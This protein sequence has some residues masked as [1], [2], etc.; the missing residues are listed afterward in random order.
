VRG[1]GRETK[2][3]RIA[4][5][6]IWSRWQAG[7]PI[8]ADGYT[9]W[10]STTMV[11]DHNR[12]TDRGRPVNPW[13]FQRAWSR[14]AAD[15]VQKV[16]RDLGVSPEKAAMLLEHGYV[17]PDRDGRTTYTP[18]FEE[19]KRRE[20]Q[21]RWPQVWDECG[22]PEWKARAQ[23]RVR[24]ALRAAVAAGAVPPGIRVEADYA[25][26]GHVM[27]HG[28]SETVAVDPD[29]TVRRLGCRIRY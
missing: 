6:I 11:A 1:M 4:D 13:A 16:A 23:A 15:L 5:R 14:L 3:E 27:I 22:S 18:L 26:T 21:A 7:L 10:N 24:E 28:P 29:N 17:M 12:R 25:D 2:A 19:H 20:E 8:I 9:A